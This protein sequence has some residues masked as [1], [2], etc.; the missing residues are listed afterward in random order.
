M[1]KFKSIFN[2]KY[3]S[4]GLKAHYKIRLKILRYMP[5]IG[6]VYFAFII[7]IS[8]IWGS[9]LSLSLLD[10]IM[11]TS[12]IL[13]PFIYHYFNTINFKNDSQ[14]NKE[15][16]WEVSSESIRGFN[17]SLQFR[18]NWKDIRDVHKLRDG[19]IIYVGKNSYYWFPQSDFNV[20][21]SDSEIMEFVR[22]N[23]VKYS[24]KD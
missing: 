7:A 1:I 24:I 18:V 20:N 15:I 2:D 8:L 12:F 3:L 23:N 4:D 19:I 17:D 14:Y 13:F 6:I 10:V 22:A 5:L 11:I 16:N 9:S 21:N